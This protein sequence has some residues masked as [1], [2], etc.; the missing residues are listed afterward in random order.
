MF[1]YRQTQQLVFI[2]SVKMRL[3]TTCVFSYIC[4]LY[5]IMHICYDNK[6]RYL[7]WNFRTGAL[8]SFS[9]AFI[10]TMEATNETFD[11]II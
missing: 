9:A 1:T 11:V 2:W 10:G 8:Q 3:T 5:T 7:L 6:H 4:V